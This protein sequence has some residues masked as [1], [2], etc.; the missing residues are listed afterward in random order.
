PARNEQY[1][2][3]ELLSRTNALGNG[4]LSAGIRKG[5][6]VCIYMDSCP[7]YLISYLAIWR[8]GA[9]AVPTNIVYRE[10]ELLHAIRD[11]GA[12]GLITHSSAMPVV[13]S[14]RHQAPSLSVVIA[15]GEPV[16]GALYL[17]EIYLGP[18]I[19]TAA[20]CSLEDLCQ[21]QYT[22]GTTGRPKGAM[23]THGNWMAALDAEREV[24][25]LTEDDVYL[26]IYP[27]GHVGFSWGLAAL[28]AG[29]T[30]V[31][32]ERFE[33]DRY[34]SLVESHKV[35][36]LSAMPP[37]IHTLLSSPSGTEGRLSTVR[38]MISGGGPLLPSVWEGFDRRFHI[39]IANAYGLSETIVVGSATCVLPEHYSLHQNYQSV[40]A[41]VGY[42]EVC[43]VNESDPEIGVSPGV[44]GEIAVRGPAVAK[45]YFG[46][47][48]ETHEVFRPDGW[49]LTGDLG[50]LDEE[51][52][53]HITDRKK[54]M[55]IMSGWKIY[56]A[57][58][59]NVLIQHPLVGD[60]AVFGRADERR[61]EIPVA[62]VVP[63][64]GQIP[65]YEEIASFCRERL[66]GYKVP[67][68]LVIVSSLPRVNGWKL[69]RR[70]LREKFH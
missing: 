23:L 67:R 65:T 34:L 2:F 62:A 61:G 29:A 28:K 55:I 31:I 19:L 40:G 13:Q 9:I 37:V 38:V 58:V 20:H 64:D 49:F 52:V 11:S 53:L 33:V 12:R 3:R 41:P 39:P 26:G 57:E 25:S 30:F 4:L 44:I 70:E 69:L 48:E 21:L 5:D 54:D 42:A 51:G 60:A 18:D 66:A 63:K 15:A 35:T 22:A 6:R 50:F 32:M 1:T 45:G 14:I 46:M 8:I 7:E 27:L 47:P 56:P 36:V 16:Q 17:E 24:L 59:E 10:A 68:D 43:I